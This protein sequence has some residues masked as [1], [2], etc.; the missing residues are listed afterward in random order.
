[1]NLFERF[2]KMVKEE[3]GYT[4]VKKTDRDKKSFESLFGVS[5]NDIDNYELPY[6][7]ECLEER[8]SSCEECFFSK[9]VQR[10][11]LDRTEN[12]LFCSKHGFDVD[13]TEWCPEGIKNK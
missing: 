9:E 6:T 13:K 8:C 1:M 11:I 10:K 7:E 3:F 4:V 12:V 2:A 5:C